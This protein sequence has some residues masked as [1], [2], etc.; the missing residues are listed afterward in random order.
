M[1]LVRFTPALAL[2]LAFGCSS[3]DPAPA[4]DASIDA[5]DDPAC[6]ADWWDCE[7]KSRRS[8]EVAAT[9][10]VLANFPLL[11]SLSSSD[12]AE[13]PDQ[14]TDL[15]FV[16]PQGALLPYEIDNWATGSGAQVW[17]RVP[18]VAA[19]A[20]TSLTMYWGNAAAEAPTN[21]EQVWADGFRGVWHLNQAS[22]DEAPDATGNLNVG[23]PMGLEVDAQQAGLVGGSIEFDG[24][25]DWL[26]VAH[27]SSLDVTESAITLSAWA[28]LTEA[29]SRD[30]GLIVKATPD[31]TA[32]NYQIGIQGADFA[33]FRTLT[34]TQSY[35]T[36]L[37]PL[38]TLR[39]YYIT[40]VYDGSTSTIYVN[41]HADKVTPQAGSIV[42]V[43]EP[44]L[45]GRRA[46]T[47]NRFF[48]GKIDEARVS[49]LARSQAWIRAEYRNLT[50]DLVSL[51]EAEDSLGEADDI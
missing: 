45:M 48:T 26:E 7:Y 51:G 39:W 4:A 44:L 31:F 2:C 19:D 12:I 20:P 38:D 40:G 30:S 50:G 33:N 6:P 15:R 37:S 23:A 11:V 42:S 1:I 32:Y 46:L 27:S 49:T 5:G 35:L 25:N 14:G 28:Y 17:V 34:D 29:P 21:G 13:M 18:S 41:G 9:E 16:G 10:E 3:N 36:G 8:V 43:T 47:D 22:L 24:V